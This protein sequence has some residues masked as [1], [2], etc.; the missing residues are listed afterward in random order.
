MPRLIRPRKING[1]S[2]SS[3]PIGPLIPAKTVRVR[4]SKGTSHNVG[5]TTS[6]MNSIPDSANAKQISEEP[7]MIGPVLAT[8]GTN[9]GNA[10][11]RAPSPRASKD[12]NGKTAKRDSRYARSP[13]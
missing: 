2:S 6:D 8:S 9:R 11:R 5:T 10:A 1:R 4:S 12:A 13:T 7:M 3:F